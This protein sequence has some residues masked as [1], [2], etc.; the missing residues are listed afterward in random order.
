MYM[1][2]MYYQL[3]YFWQD[4]KFWNYTFDIWEGF[5]PEIK[6]IETNGPLGLE[7]VGHFIKKVP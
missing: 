5:C 6:S 3:Y 4:Q 1:Y 7:K 2:Y